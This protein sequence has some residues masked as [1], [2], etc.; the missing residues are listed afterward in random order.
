MSQTTILEPFTDAY[1]K[2]IGLKQ[3][4]TTMNIEEYIQISHTLDMFKRRVE[5][6]IDVAQRLE[7]PHDYPLYLLESVNKAKLAIEQINERRVR[8]L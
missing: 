1:F 6:D 5:N 4:A 8:S 2:E 3:T 7:K